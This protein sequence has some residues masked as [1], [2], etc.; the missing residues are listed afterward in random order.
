MQIVHHCG[1]VVRGHPVTPDQN[2]IVD[3]TGHLARETIGHGEPG[4]LGADA[5]R[6]W[7]LLP[8][9]RPFG[10]GEPRAGPRIGTMTLTVWGGRGLLDLPARAETLV[11]AVP[12]PGEGIAVG[13]QPVGLRHDLAVPGHSQ[14]PEVGQLPVSGPTGC[15][16]P[17]R[18]EVL[19]AQQ[20]PSL[21]PPG[22]EPTGKRCAQIPEVQIGGRGGRVTVDDRHTPIVA[23][24][25]PRYPL[26]HQVTREMRCR[27]AN[28]R[29]C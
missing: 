10:S 21:L 5:D 29:G 8:A 14:P 22:Q 19:D 26:T 16:H 27:R 7:T 20:P 23:G 1:E 2:E 15:P 9:S 12:Q 13:V 6:G 28:Q 18:V 11:G 4:A 17:G 24:R 25:S 3:D